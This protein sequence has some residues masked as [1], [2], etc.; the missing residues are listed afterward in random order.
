MVPPWFRLVWVFRFL[1]SSCWLLPT[2][3]ISIYSMGSCS[4]SFCPDFSSCRV[5][6]AC[7][8][9][10][11]SCPKFRAVCSVLGAGCFSSCLIAGSSPLC[12]VTLLFSSS[13]NAISGILYPKAFSNSSALTGYP[14]RGKLL[15]M[16]EMALPVP[17]FSIFFSLVFRS[18]AGQLFHYTLTTFFGQPC[19]FCA[20]PGKR[21]DDL[22]IRYGA[23]V[24]PDLRFFPERIA[25]G[26]FPPL[27]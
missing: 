12:C 9:A 2:P 5:F 14:I 25:R 17:S 18:F 8:R 15:S 6:P 13:F 10:R 7:I 20:I 11:I 21:L 22:S 27:F 1:S 23:A 16:E 26:K 4:C 3:L 24:S 19:T